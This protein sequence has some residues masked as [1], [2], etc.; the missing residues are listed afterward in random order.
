MTDEPIGDDTAENQAREAEARRRTPRLELAPR[1]KPGCASWRKSCDGSGAEKRA[2]REDVRTIAPVLSGFLLT[3]DFHS[4]PACCVQPPGP[5]AQGRSHWWTSCAMDLGVGQVGLVADGWHDDR[6]GFG[7]RGFEHLEIA[8][9]DDPVFVA[10]EQE[11][12][13]GDRRQDGRR[14]RPV[15]RSTRWARDRIGV[16]PFCSM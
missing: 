11:D 4:Q 3:S 1:L 7:Q 5:S 6:F 16:N 15:R 14:S 9:G 12:L 10:L 2:D 8:M 13:R